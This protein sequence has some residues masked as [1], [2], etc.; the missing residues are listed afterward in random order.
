MIG[1]TLSHFRITD[2]LG[3]GGMGEVWLARDTRLGRTVALKTL[4]PARAESEDRRRRFE[5]E[6][7]AASVLNH[8]GIA[9][10]YDIGEADGVH[11]IAMEHVAG[12]SL[13]HWMERQPP[14]T[15]EILG[16]GAQLADALAA[17]HDHG[18]THRD[19][20]PSNLMVTPEGR[21]KILD[22]GLAKLQPT[23]GGDAEDTAAT[24]TQPGVVMGTVQYMSPEQALGKNADHRSDLFSTGVVLYQ[25]ATGR[26]PFQGST[27]TETITEIVRSEPTPV[28]ELS[29]LSPP[30]LERIIRK[31]MEKDPARRY[32]SAREL[33]VDLNNLK[34]D[35]DSGVAVVTGQV[36][37]SKP[38]VRYVL[39]GAAALILAAALFVGGNVMTSRGD[40]IGSIA[41]LPFENGTGDT[42]SDYLCDGLTEGLINTLAQI[43]ELKVISRR[44]AYA[45]KD[46]EEDPQAIGRKLG[47]QALL[48]G[49]LVQRGAQLAV[50]AELVDVNDNHQL[51]GGRFDRDQADVLAI[52]KE[53]TNT[54]AQTL[55]IEL[56][57]DTAKNLDRRY[58]VDPEAYRLYL[59][60]R[61]FSVGSAKEMHKAVD[62]FQRAIAMD[63][64]YAQPYAGLA[65]AYMTQ[66][67]H[68]VMDQQE[69]LERSKAAIA[70]ALELD[71]MLAEALAASGEIKYYF[72]WDWVGAENDLKRAVELNPG[73][74]FARVSYGYF[75]SAVGRFDDAIEQAT[76]AKEL[77]P[78]SPAAFH[79]VAYS[80]MGK[81]EY[82]RAAAEF[83]AA[84][85][86]N[87][88]WTW[89]YIKLA[90]T[91]ADNGQCEE[92]LA[93]AEDAEAQLHGG[94]TPLARSWVGYTYGRCGDTKRAEAA[95]QTLDE[96]AEN[97]EVDPF[98][99]GII[100]A[101]LGDTDRL[102]DEIE[103]A[104]D[105]HSVLAV[106]LP[107]VPAYYGP[108]LENDLRFQTLMERTGF[109]GSSVHEGVSE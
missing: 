64:G 103:R 102:L 65:D 80:F 22:F 71:P 15:F 54:I 91:Y 43:P 36:R 25:M 31:S 4:P 93:T 24:M 58:A 9:H 34:R 74:D 33:A 70:Q 41:V 95:L 88:N 81:H 72:E 55:R 66:A 101:G 57:P 10:I 30:E 108:G 19:I 89:G 11:F 85:D 63:P 82:D 96:F 17:A 107:A 73:S 12:K 35:T 37:A 7:R 61:K 50:S 16:F 77:D 42:E 69:A 13:G 14:T 104:I 46:S 105:A 48:M 8:P 84:L 51:W 28:S 100:Y 56:S 75:L 29:P 32:Q 52:E 6:A 38:W 99:Y 26:L 90:K 47:V 67:L 1:R 76:V 62:Y 45:F 27:P 68:D 97:T 87:P 23:V 98:A 40:A 53:L 86:L 92:A 60:G 5:D 18:V 94:D 109:T 106:F 79:L 49:R 44:S 21:L 3:E 83:R 78:L 2:K 20:K 39:I 59:Q